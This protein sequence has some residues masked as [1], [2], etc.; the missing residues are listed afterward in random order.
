MYYSIFWFVTIELYTSLTTI[1]HFQGI[2]YRYLFIMKPSAS[3]CWVK[4]SHALFLIKI[5]P[6][7]FVWSYSCLSFFQSLLLFATLPILKNMTR[8]MTSCTFSRGLVNSGK[9]FI[10][11]GCSFLLKEKWRWQ[12]GRVFIQNGTN[13]LVQGDLLIKELL[14]QELQL[15]RLP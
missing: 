15:L 3:F 14:L 4:S 12:K 10:S 8:N 1:F 9:A 2:I 5:S 11:R 13:E 7:F 6:I